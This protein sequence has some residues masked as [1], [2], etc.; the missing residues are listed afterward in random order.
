M[1]YSNFGS[2]SYVELKM[3]TEKDTCLLDEAVLAPAKKYGK[4][5]AQVVL[6]WALQ[7]GTCVIPKTTKPER[8]AE[9]L[10]LFDFALTADEMKAIA[11]LNKGERYNCPSK[12]PW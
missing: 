5:P 4:T 11:A 6:R 9:N 1:A 10:A 2:L 3:A 7:R 8:L 12:Y